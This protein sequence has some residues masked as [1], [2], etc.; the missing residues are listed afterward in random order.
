MLFSDKMTLFHGTEPQNRQYI[1]LS[2]H[3]SKKC[4]WKAYSLAGSALGAAGGTLPCHCGIYS[5]S[6]NT[7][8]QIITKVT[9]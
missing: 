5:M 4:V 2:V 7:Y 9:L 1:H 8:Q 6:E 3:P